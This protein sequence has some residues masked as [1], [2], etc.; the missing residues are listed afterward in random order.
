MSEL[1][2]TIDRYIYMA[3]SVHMRSCVRV[4]ML[5][6]S[7]FVVNKTI[8]VMK[9]DAL[10]SSHPLIVPRSSPEE[11]KNAFDII[12]YSKVTIYEHY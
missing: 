2:F 12:T 3:H 7:T 1:Q 4:T 8:E 5:Q 11:I 6:D 10:L 9:P